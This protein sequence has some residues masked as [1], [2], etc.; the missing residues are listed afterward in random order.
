MKKI[1]LSISFTAIFALYIFLSNRNSISIILPS[2]TGSNVLNSPLP[3]SV[4]KISSGQQVSSNNIVLSPMMSSSMGQT[5]QTMQMM[6]GYKDGSYIG[7]NADAYFGNIQVKA[8]IQNGKISDIQFINYP[9]DQNTS[10]K[11]SERAMP[12]LKTEAIQ[13]Q[14]AQ[15]DI[16]SGATQT[17]QG[18]MQ[19]L[20]DALVA[21]KN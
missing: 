6:G 4:N 21:A 5:A 18:F 15:V 7:M 11:I 13:A 8:I 14:S 2:K 17:S 19:S 10:K 16:V 1:I 20:A 3:T 9:S 12:I